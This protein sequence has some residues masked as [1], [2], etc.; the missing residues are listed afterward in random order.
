MSPWPTDSKKL[1]LREFAPGTGEH[2][3]A[4]HGYKIHIAYSGAQAVELVTRLFAEGER[5]AC[6]FFDMKMPGG[7]DGLETIRQI[8]AINPQVVCT[9]V[10][11][12]NQYSLD[13]IGEAFGQVI[14]MT[15]TI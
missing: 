4:Q 6:G 2:Q 14:L 11:S 1:K 9:I 7:M 3:L 5:I 15:G 10:T 13:E 12:F 8:R